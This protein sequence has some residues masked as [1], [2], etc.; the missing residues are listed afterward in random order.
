MSTTG[1][2]L[3]GRVGRVLDPIYRADTATGG[4]TTTL[5]SAKWPWKDSGQG[6][7]RYVGKVVVRPD[8]ALA[9]DTYRTIQVDA[10]TTGTLTP[11]DAWTNA[12][13]ATEAFE[14][15][16]TFDPSQVLDYANR[17]AETLNVLEE[18]D[19]VGVSGQRQYSLAA[20]PWLT[21]PDQV[22]ATLL[23]TGSTAGAYLYDT[24]PGAYVSVDEAALTLNLAASMVG[25][26]DTLRILAVRDYALLA[27]LATFASATDAPLAWLAYETCLLMLREPAGGRYAPD[28][29]NVMQRLELDIERKCIYFRDLYAPKVSRRLFA[30]APYFGPR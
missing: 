24:F 8:A 19:V 4:T 14:V 17:A 29:D 9:S 20:Y 23:R 26:S 10:P 30:V 11:Y 16:G 1:G 5:V 13:I 15:W 7:S 2:A 21:R 25:P 3:R 27:P 6:A 18:V 12:P 22:V 28:M